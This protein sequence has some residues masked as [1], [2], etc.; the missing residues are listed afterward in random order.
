MIEPFDS[1]SAASL[2]WRMPI[3]PETAARVGLVLCLS[4]FVSCAP[5][6][7]RATRDRMLGAWEL[8]SRTVK[9]AGGDT[10]RKSVV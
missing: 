2:Y 7:G 3:A 4:V 9:N 6:A 10:D 5:S 1:D 8:R